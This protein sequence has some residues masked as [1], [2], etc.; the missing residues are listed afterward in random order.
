[1][2]PPGI[3]S[4]AYRGRIMSQEHIAIVAVILRHREPART[5]AS[6]SSRAVRSTAQVRGTSSET[7]NA[8]NV[9]VYV[10][11]FDVEEFTSPPDFAV[12]F[13]SVLGGGGPFQS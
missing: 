13:A 10:T 2:F 5:V 12:G 8:G 11:H 3:V 1:M 9:C 7:G 6:W 4:F